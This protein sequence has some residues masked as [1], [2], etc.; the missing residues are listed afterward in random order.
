V[1]EV[2]SKTAGKYPASRSMKS[3]A[4]P[5]RPLRRCIAA[6][7]ILPSDNSAIADSWSNQGSC[8]LDKLH[9]LPC[10]PCIFLQQDKPLPPSGWL[11]RP[12]WRGLFPYGCGEHIHRPQFSARN[13]LPHGN[14]DDRTTA[15]CPQFNQKCPG[16][17][18][19]PWGARYI[20]EACPQKIKKRVK[21]CLTP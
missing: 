15:T 13:Q 3:P 16:R 20:R 5:P 9:H 11:A 17:L 2:S 14:G 18:P 4:V 12:R 7:W 21:Y 1:S 19:S 10:Y 6:S 8:K